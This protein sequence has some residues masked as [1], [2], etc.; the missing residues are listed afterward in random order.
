MHTSTFSSPRMRS[1]GGD[2]F[3]AD[4]PGDYEG[5]VGSDQ[6]YAV[7]FRPPPMGGEVL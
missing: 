1:Y 6:S 2:V 7:C 4:K 3:L 5:V